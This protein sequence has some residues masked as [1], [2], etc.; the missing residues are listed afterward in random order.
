MKQHIIFPG[1]LPDLN[2][3]IDKCR[4]HWANGAKMKKE[5]QTSAE[6]VI[7]AARLKPITGPVIISFLWIEPNYKRDP[8]NIASFGKKVILDALVSQK[9]LPND[10][11]KWVNGFVDNYDVDKLIPRIEINIIDI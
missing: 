1:T 6:W 10:S 7:R 9:I 2:D 3:Y 8:D 4:G 11:L 5:H